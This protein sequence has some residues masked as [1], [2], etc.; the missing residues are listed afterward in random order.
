MPMQP[1]DCAASSHPIRSH[2]AARSWDALCKL[3]Q[4]SI[5]ECYF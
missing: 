4:V 5:P 2:F 3:L 1:T